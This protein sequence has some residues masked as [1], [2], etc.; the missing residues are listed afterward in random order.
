MATKDLLAGVAGVGLG[1]H[2]QVQ[3]AVPEPQV[4][5]LLLRPGHHLLLHR[6]DGRQD[7][8]QRDTEGGCR[9][10]LVTACY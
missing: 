10:M 3:G 2:P 1:Q 4:H 8:G 9:I 6:G 5:H 7:A